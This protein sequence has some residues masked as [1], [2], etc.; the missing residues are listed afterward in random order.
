MSRLKDCLRD[1]FNATLSI[2]SR[3][4]LFLKDYM[5]LIKGIRKIQNHIFGLTFHGEVA[6]KFAAPICFLAA[7]M[8]KQTYDIKITEQPLFTEPMYRS[9]NQ[10]RKLDQH[11]FDMIATAIRIVG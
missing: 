9:V 2:I 8:I 4:A 10:I 1:T 6:Y 11:M 3:G 5:Y 7:M